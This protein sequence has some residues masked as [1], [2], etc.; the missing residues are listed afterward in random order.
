MKHTFELD[1]TPITFEASENDAE[2]VRRVSSDL[3]GMKGYVNMDADD[4]VSVLDGA[5]VISAGEGTA[6]G[7]DKVKAAT[8][9]AM[10][11]A[12]GISGA[13]SLI[14]EVVS[15][16]DTFLSEISDAAFTIE[17]SC[18]EDVNVVWGHVLDGNMDDSVRVNIIAVG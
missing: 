2:T 7:D 11:N 10:K 12:S 3:L 6:S 14:V 8:L 9:E 15:G 5:K 1:G 13:K 17:G 18:K 4:I 16:V